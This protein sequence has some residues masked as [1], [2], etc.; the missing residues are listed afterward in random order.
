[1]PFGSIP[2]VLRVVRTS[3]LT[4]VTPLGKGP[5]LW[6]RSFGRESRYGCCYVSGMAL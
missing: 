2:D 5:Q 6:K 4:C 1:M 3:W